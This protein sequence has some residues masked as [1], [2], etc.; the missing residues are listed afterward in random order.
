MPS[1]KVADEVR[2]LSVRLPL[3]VFEKLRAKAEEHGQTVGA[4]VRAELGR[5]V[6]VEAIVEW[7]E[8]KTP[9]MMIVTSDPEVAEKIERNRPGRDPARC[10]CVKPEPTPYGVC[11]TCG[12]RR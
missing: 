10:S 7:A 1:R 6:E 9:E 3:P 5:L 2:V 8:A 11:K 4:L 12:K